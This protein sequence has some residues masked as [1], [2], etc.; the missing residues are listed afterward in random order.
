MI[1]S[2][3]AGP[4][5]SSRAAIST[6]VLDIRTSNVVAFGRHCQLTAG[7]SGHKRTSPVG[8]QPA[9]KEAISRA[10]R[11]ALALAKRTNEWDEGWTGGTSGGKRVEAGGSGAGGHAAVV[12][13]VPEPSR[14]VQLAGD[15]GA[16]A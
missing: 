2:A 1:R 14:R 16:R 8:S 15:H 12:L 10:P 3:N 13:H 11:M 6:T 5:A 7:P 9:T 4:P